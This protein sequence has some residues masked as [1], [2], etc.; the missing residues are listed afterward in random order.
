MS[1]TPATAAEEPTRTIA[2]VAYPGITVLDLVGPLQV[3]S[4]LSYL[5]PGF[6]TVVV[7]ERIEPMATDTPLSV[8]PSHTFEEVPDPY[9]VLVPGGLVPTLAALADQRLLG[10]LR[11]LA[12]GAELVGSVCTGSLLLA[13]AGL[14]EGR[15]ATTHWWYRDLLT[16][17]GATPVAER[18]VADGR[19]IT[20]AGVSA[21]IDMALQLVAQVAGEPLAREVQLIIEYDPQPPFGAIDWA[22][23]DIASYAPIA[24]GALRQAL[25]DH[26]ELYARLTDEK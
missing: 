21:G 11:Q 24:Q 14:L 12:E 1:E 25:V 8:V 20:A 9:A 10:R 3:C 6:R 26:P 15:R 13:A 5:A 2:F 17:F 22:G 19:F 16:R 7:G 23:T 4:A 18:W